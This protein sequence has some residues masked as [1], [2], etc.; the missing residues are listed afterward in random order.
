MSPYPSPTLRKFKERY[1]T[2]VFKYRYLTDIFLY[3]TEISKRK[4]LQHKCP[5]SWGLGEGTLYIIMF[6]GGG[7]QFIDQYVSAQPKNWVIL[8]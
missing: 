6:F 5:K 4:P 3:L 8:S 2:E 1:L 7:V